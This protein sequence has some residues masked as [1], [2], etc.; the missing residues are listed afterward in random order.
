MNVRDSAVKK[1]WNPSKKTEKKAEQEHENQD[2]YERIGYCHNER[3]D[4]SF[5]KLVES[6]FKKHRK[7][8]CHYDI[9][10]VQDYGF[11]AYSYSET[12]GGIRIKTL[13]SPINLRLMEGLEL[14]SK[15]KSE[16]NLDLSDKYSSDEFDSNEKIENLVILP[17][18]NLKDQINFDYID[19]LFFIDNVPLKIK[20]HPISSPKFIE[21]LEE[22]YG[23][24]NVLN[25]N[26]SLQK[27]FKQSKK[28]FTGSN[29]EYSVLSLLNGK[30]TE[31]ITRPKCFWIS[32]YCDVHQYLKDIPKEK[33]KSTFESAVLNNKSGY[34]FK[35]QEDLEE[36]IKNYFEYSYQINQEYNTSLKRFKDI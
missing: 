20:P 22:K 12:F 31:I 15:K 1:E 25:V 14:N 30:E 17:G 6:L 27:I 3:D 9:N 35:F 7:Y 2:H 21:A 5:L 8:P 29:S 10:T 32:T 34:F 16:L 19:K 13:S 33:R 28:I 36:R 4:K 23:I 24:E 26:A 18:N 11:Q